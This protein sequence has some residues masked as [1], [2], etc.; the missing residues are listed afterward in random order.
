M[1]PPNQIMI[2]VESGTPRKGLIVGSTNPSAPALYVFRQ[3]DDGYSAVGPL[4][5]VGLAFVFDEYATLHPPHIVSDD[6]AEAIEF[7]GHPKAPRVPPAALN[8]LFSLWPTLDWID[9][10]FYLAPDGTLRYV[11]TAEPVPA[12]DWPALATE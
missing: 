9:C 2:A 4:L 7:D 1:T 8:G 10:E 5:A 6:E 12:E 11:A 3:P